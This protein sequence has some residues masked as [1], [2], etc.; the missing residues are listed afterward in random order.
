V[1]RRDGVLVREDVRVREEHPRSGGRRDAEVDVLREPPRRA[2][3]EDACR[4]RELRRDR[5]RQVRDH[6][7]L[8][9]LRREEG[10]ERRELRRVPV[11]D[12]DGRDLG[13][14]PSASR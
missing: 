2:V 10:K 3:L 9:D 5:G 4:H 12:D 11:R 1:E 13:H 14:A 7:D 8:V 6:D